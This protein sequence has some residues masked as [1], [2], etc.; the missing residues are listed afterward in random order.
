M[1]EPVAA[2]LKLE[3]NE[4]LIKQIDTLQIP[5]LKTKKNAANTEEMHLAI[6]PLCGFRKWA[7]LKEIVGEALQSFPD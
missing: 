1:I 2:P 4:P 6:E 3:I 7:T 5:I